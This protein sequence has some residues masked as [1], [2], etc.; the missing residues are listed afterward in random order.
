[1][2]IEATK[3][4]TQLVN[5]A[6]GKLM[7]V[8]SGQSPDAEDFDKVNAKV[9]GLIL[10]LSADEVCE[11]ANDDEIPTEWF[12]DLASLLANRCANDFGKAYSEDAKKIFEGHLT[13]MTRS[14]MTNTLKVERAVSGGSSVY[15][16]NR[17]L[18]GT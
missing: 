11:I 6:L 13:G 8:G 17:W 18:R 9:D 4:R 1:M 10:Q 12:D 5:D 3:T 2:S 14:L 7:V 16:Y 15:S